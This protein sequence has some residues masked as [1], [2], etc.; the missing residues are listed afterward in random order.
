[1]PPHASQARIRLATPD[2]AAEVA[3]IY[4]PICTHTPISFEEAAPSPD[5]MAGRIRL[6]GRNLSHPGEHPYTKNWLAF[7]PA[8]DLPPCYG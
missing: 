5:E 8:Q 1:M 2:D 6:P 7:H 3:A 4:G